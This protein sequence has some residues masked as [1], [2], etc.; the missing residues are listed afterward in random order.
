MHGLSGPLTTPNIY[1]RLGFIYTYNQ[2]IELCH[3]SVRSVREDSA[4]L[5]LKSPFIE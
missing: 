2:E 1:E 3:G 4:I 5:L